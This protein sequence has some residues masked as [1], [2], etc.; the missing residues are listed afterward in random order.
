MYDYDLLTIGAGSGG[1][2]G[3][4]RAAEYGA[5]VAIVEAGRV[6]GTCVLR[7]CVPKKLLV[8][9]ARFRDEI[10][11]ARG[12]G[13]TI[14]GA[15]HDWG[16]L[17]ETKNRELVRLEGIYEQMLA[18]SGV[19]VLR[20][21]GRVTGPHEVEV[22]GRT[23]TAENILIAT[24]SHPYLPKIPGIEHVIT[25][26]EALDL[27]ALPGRIVIIGGGYIA[28]EFASILSTLG[29]ATTLVLRSEQILRGFDG[30]V[31]EAVAGEMAARGIDFRRHVEPVRIDRLAEGFAVTL[32]S[33]EVLE[34][35]L[36]M[37]ATGRVP[38]TAALGLDAIGIHTRD[39]G[40]IVVNDRFETHI[41][42]IHAVGDVTDRFQLTPV[43]IAEARSLAER[44]YNDN[45]YKLRYDT[46]P[47]AVFC[48]PQI[49]TVGLTEEAARR[50]YASI[51]IFRARFRPMKHTL[52]GRETRILMKL[53]VDAASDRVLGAHMVGDDA[54]EIIQS[55]AVA[56]T[57]GATK[58]QFDETIALHPSAAEE[59]VTMRT[60]VTD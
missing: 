14:D 27:P 21:R 16:R 2:A 10:E 28:T 36:V 29:A 23:V 51:R 8:Y 59:F 49:G 52:T 40:A 43:A 9:G 15:R 6:G 26:D 34:T 60:P 53:V 4:R 50:M 12:F 5:R 18:N 45:G 25:S 47:T 30:D 35:D 33:G 31:R 41:R 44:L 20:G 56:I 17:I 37:F 55:L 22:D 42:S 38:N 11:D 39:N 46:L 24:G 54:A 57:C 48:T 13:W 58:K 19:T 7:G 1:V 3:S 32:T